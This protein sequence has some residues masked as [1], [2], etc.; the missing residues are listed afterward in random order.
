MKTAAAYLR[1]SDERQDE[2]SPDSQLKLIRDYCSRNDMTLPD[3]LVFYDDGISAK[4]VK[5]RKQFNEMIAL[6]KQKNPPFSVILVWKFSRFA[7]NQE[8]S[9]VYKSMLKKNGVDVISVSEPIQDNPFGGL[10]ERIIEWMDEYYLIR[11]SD[12]VRRGMTERATRGLPNTHAPFGYKMK[13]GEYEADENTAKWV[14][15]IFE[16][17]SE[18]VTKRQI[19]M[20]LRDLDVRNQNN[21]YLD[22]RNVDYILNNPVY[23]GY[24]RWNPHNRT[25]SAR[26]FGDSTDIVVK[27]T[28]EP[29]I[30]E[31]TWKKTQEL[32]M[33]DEKKYPYKAKTSAQKNRYMLRGLVKCSNCGATLVFSQAGLASLQCNFYSKGKCKVSH[34]VK[35]EIIEQMVI[36]QMKADIRAMQFTLKPDFKREKPS[37]VSVDYNKLINTERAKLERAKLAYQDGVDTLEEYKAAKQRIEA[38]IIELEEEQQ[39]ELQKSSGISLKEYAKS[40]TE[41]IDVLESPNVTPDLKNEAIRSSVEKIVFYR[42]DKK[43]KIFYH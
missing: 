36:E 11:L 24:V 1:V 4:S 31:E 40:L 30:S 34:S 2:F 41:L 3:E 27:S 8:E 16:W 43:V 15:K 19:A 9:I 39:K 28:H 18:G 25:S 20:R 10:I 6:A 33:M 23:L 12:E 14:R 7:R 17:Y 38:K 21:N 13:D 5:K 26:K 32:L 35:M 37:D 42:P 22:H 29:L